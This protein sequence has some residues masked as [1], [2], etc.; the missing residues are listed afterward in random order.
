MN[1]VGNRN[2]LKAQT[3]KPAKRGW[4]P[5][6]VF[7]VSAGVLATLWGYNYNSGNAEE[8][9]P[10]ILR[11][12]NPDF[13]TND[14][15]TNTFNQF[16]PRTI[17][18]EFIAVLTRVAPLPAILFALTLAGNIAIAFLSSLICKHFFPDAALSPFFAAAGVLTLKTFWL[19]YSNIL[20]RNFLEPEHLAMPFI[21]L[22]FFWILKKKF[23]LSALAFGVASLFHALL[24]LEI[25]W[26]LIAV[27]TL[28]G[29]IGRF[30]KEPSQT[31][32]RPLMVGTGL[33]AVIS[34]AILLP[35]TLQESIPADEF[36]RLVAYVRHPHHYLPSTFEPWQY[37]QAAVYWL[38][39]CLIFAFSRT[40]STVLGSWKRYFYLVGGLLLLLCLGGYLFV[41]IWPSRLWTSAQMFR[42]LFLVKWFSIVLIGGWTGSILER[43]DEEYS[44]WFGISAL[45]AL[46]TP[47]SLAWI[48][49]ARLARKWILPK[50]RLPSWLLHDF[51]IL[52]VTLGL[53]IFYKP[54]LRTWF[55]FFTFSLMILLLGTFRHQVWG[56]LTTS[57]V[58][59]GLAGILVFFSTWG[60]TPE[61]LK[62]QVPFFGLYPST[63][64]TAEMAAFAR[65]STPSD[66]IFLT[67]P[68]FGEFRTMAERAIVVDFV[69]YPFQDLSMKEWYQR[70]VDCYTSTD[71]LGFAAVPEINKRFHAISDETLLTIADKYG[72]T[73]AVVYDDTPT[74]FPVIFRTYSL[75]MIEIPTP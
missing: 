41:E 3:L 67:L 52:A 42:L 23:I 53:V 29:W 72:V 19:G 40:R 9:L 65:E 32:W 47:V 17:Y 30:R 7:C 61:F 46:V 66:A 14:F 64:E 63:G 34:V 50:L 39:F 12:I 2:S 25:G 48:A 27:T 24:G 70:M 68:K 15:F 54:E 8:Q 28:E 51:V 20:Y 62:Y 75:K 43:P 57:L 37:G 6:L 4:L 36:I 69:A 55:L 13:L 59:L 60:G 35:Y 38:G 71:L 22:G 26:I 18:S 31:Q 33:L 56:F 58:I 73:Y 5:L 44:R 16:G 49:L 21:L 74:N 11:A 10:F 45:I 1:L